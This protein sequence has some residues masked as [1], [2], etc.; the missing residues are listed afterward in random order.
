MT[1]TGFGI[2]YYF[3]G[4]N[5]A[6]YYYTREG[7]TVTLTTSNNKTFGI[8]SLMDEMGMKGY[9]LY[10]EELD[11]T[12]E[13]ENGASL[14]LDGLHNATYKSTTVNV[15]GSYVTEESAFGQLIT[16]SATDGNTYKFLITSETVEVPDES[17]DAEPDAVIKQTTYYA[18]QKHS[19]Y[20]EYY[21]SQYDAIKGEQTSYYAP[22]IVFN[23]PTAGVATIY[24]FKTDKS[25][26]VKI[27]TAKITQDSKT[28]LYTLSDITAIPYQDEIFNEPIDFSKVKTAIFALDTEMGSLAI[29]YWY[30]WTDTQGNS[31]YFDKK[32]ESSV[33]NDNAILT[34]VGGI[35]IYDKNGTLDIGL[36]STQGNLLAFKTKS[37]TLYF[38]INEAN[39]TF[40]KLE[41]SPYSAYLMNSNG[42]ANNNE[43][44]SFDGKGGA[45]YVIKGKTVS[46]DTKIPGTLTKTDETVDGYYVYTFKATDNSKDI[47]FI[48]VTVDNKAYFLAYSDAN[49]GVYTGA[50]GATLKLDGYCYRASYNDK[51]GKVYNGGYV[52]S[53]D[54]KL[55]TFIWE[56]GGYL[57][58]DINA[59]GKTF[60]VKGREYGSYLLY[61]NQSWEGYYLDFDGYGKLVVYTAKADQTEESGYKRIPVDNEATYE[62]IGEN[63]YLI[64]FKYEG[65]NMAFT[66]VLGYVS[67]GGDQYYQTFIVS[68]EEFVKVYVNESDWSVIILDDIGNATRYDKNGV[69]ERG[70]Y[71]VITDKLFYFVNAGYTDACIYEYDNENGKIVAVDNEEVGYYTANLESLLFSRF[72]YAIFNGEEY[73]YYDIDDN[74]NV[75]IYRQD[76]MNP[77]ANTYGFVEDKEFGS[78]TVEKTYQGK[79]Y[80]KV[81]HH[82]LTFKRLESDKE[83]YKAIWDATNNYPLED[84]MFTPAGNSSTFSVAAGVTINGQQLTGTISRKIVDNKPV[85][86][87]SVASFEFD[88]EL[89][90]KGEDE[91]RMPL[92]TYKVTGM[93]YVNEMMSS[94]AMDLLFMYVYID[95][96][97][98]S[99]FSATFENTIGTIT[100][101]TVY[102]SASGIES[103]HIDG[104]FGD[105]SGMYDLNGK[106][107][108][109]KNSAYTFDE[110]TG[111][112]TVEVA[113]TDGY[114]YKV[115][116]RAEK[117]QVFGIPG[118][119]LY[120]CTR[121]Q[122]LEDQTNGYTINVERIIMSD[123]A[124]AGDIYSIVLKDKD[125]VE[126]KSEIVYENDKKLYY[127]ARE[128]DTVTGKITSTVYYVITLE[129][130][131]SIEVEEE[132][133][134][135]LAIKK[136]PPY[137]TNVT[138][139]KNETVQTKYTS[140]DKSYVDIVNGK[141]M[142]LS[143]D[144]VKY[145]AS[146]CE[147]DETTDVYTVT[148]TAKKVFMVKVVEN[149]VEIT[150]KVATEN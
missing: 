41:H 58:F 145:L 66:G 93:R 13:L 26:Y 135:P 79:N 130:D 37:G 7:N 22:Y 82:M 81:S 4:S 88:I 115:H 27:A 14:V 42:T 103:Y 97:T 116:F 61:D 52:I 67:M 29:H 8:I 92:S 74:G 90:F 96:L 51:D 24:G 62:K 110:K 64:K 5:T 71:T 77:N 111:I 31:T 48:Q 46:E 57:Y 128:T 143:I 140:D 122:T 38:E 126:I 131:T 10:A 54:R 72:G 80:T 60:T 12:F 43:Y 49:A 118:Y 45:E 112:Y 117:H 139:L 144:G 70:L 21:Y 83:N 127:V 94:A 147:Y 95:M 11:R 63:S 149:N 34:L 89:E 47:K 120:A 40:L 56:E 137:K 3:N 141:V 113:G 53:E 36:F 69:A 17:E 119:V 123:I 106:L 2:A 100:L 129:E 20:A 68:R 9:M 146:T 84:L 59:I 73:C 65:R 133:K 132:N 150:E 30:S 25:G 104:E 101:V 32:Y 23:E 76:A 109:F 28:K 50:G 33:T 107:L 136:I 1:L 125:G 91:N 19:A 18:T 138:V 6:T 142:F 134:D 105:G 98:G 108:S 102:N 85:M 86:V 78:L 44:I 99:N 55:V 114:T 75:T 35:A 39:E 87:L 121:V 148:T 15:T 124:S 16:F